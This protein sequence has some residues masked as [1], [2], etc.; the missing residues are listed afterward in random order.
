MPRSLRELRRGE[1]SLKD[2]S[3]MRERGKAVKL[4]A[5]DT[6]GHVTDYSLHHIVTM[7]WGNDFDEN[8]RD[9]RPFRLSIDRRSFVL[10]WAE[11]IEMDRAG[12]FR[13]E[14]GN[15][16][17]YRLTYLDGRRIV[18]DTAL[19]LEAERD[20]IFRLSGDGFEAY[21]DWYEMMRYGRLI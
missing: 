10:S 20:M 11:L 1:L 18:L 6:S 5:E 15:P 4:Q 16:R 17:E 13:R 8:E 14:A 3:V 19:N 9:L 12:F 2:M 7:A 21:L